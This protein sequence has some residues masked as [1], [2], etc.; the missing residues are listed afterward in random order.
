[1]MAEG[2]FDAKTLEVEEMEGVQQS[3]K[4]RP[5]EFWVDSE[6]REEG[7]GDNAKKQALERQVKEDTNKDGNGDKE[8]PKNGPPKSGP[9]VINLD[10]IYATIRRIS[11]AVTRTE[12]KVDA[13]VV[14]LKH[15]NTRMLN[16]SSEMAKTR[17]LAETNKGAIQ[18]LNRSLEE[19][20]LEVRSGAGPAS[21]SQK[22]EIEWLNAEVERLEN[23]QRKINLILVGV[24]ESANETNETL[25]VKVQSYFR[26]ILGVSGVG[27]DVTHRFGQAFKN[28]PKKV[29]VRFSSLQEKDRVWQA[30][31][32]LKNKKKPAD[33]DTPPSPIRVLQDKAKAT[34]DRDSIS[35]KILNR[36]QRTGYSRS[37]SYKKGILTIDG[38]SYKEDEYETL[39]FQ[40]RPS[41]ITTPH[42]KDTVA[43]FSRFSKFSSH[44]KATFSV[45]GKVFNCL[46]QFL[47][48]ERASIPGDTKAQKRIM[49]SSDPMVHKR[50]LNAMKGDGFE[51]E[52]RR[53][54][55]ATAIQG[56]MAKFSQN[57]DLK[58]YLLATGDKKI[59]EASPDR[60][61]GTAIALTDQRVLRQ[62]SW[63][64]ENTM[65]T[66]LQEVR[67]IL[68]RDE[69]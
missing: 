24:P 38:E 35:Y 14:E 43:F 65:G 2:G 18:D 41:T 8:P 17:N 34:R 12:D 5:G 54:A 67:S 59:G 58:G 19:L 52:W 31:E 66:V 27:I 44:Y 9:K 40:L 10:E 16:S 51:E 32:A 49:E 3:R 47:A 30:K 61:W 33:D 53:R 37:V 46:E 21:T 55:K 6:P 36:A 60:F 39:P 62:S 20:R 42:D 45:E 29:I 64:G 48:Y 25:A 63:T 4:R 26:N 13:S 56:N 15:L 68:M 23:Y 22:E 7:E 11:G 28:Q 1:M 57:S 50:Y 69:N